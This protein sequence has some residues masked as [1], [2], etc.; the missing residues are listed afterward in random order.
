MKPWLELVATKTM[1]EIVVKKLGIIILRLHVL[2][3][4]SWQGASM[5][6]PKKV[7]ARPLYI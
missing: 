5:A 3:A 1:V 4:I 2:A 6:Y 7:L